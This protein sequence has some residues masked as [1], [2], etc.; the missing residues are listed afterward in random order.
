MFTLWERF[1]RPPQHR[2][3]CRS[4]LSIINMTENILKISFCIK[5]LNYFF[6][7]L[8]TSFFRLFGIG[9]MV[10]RTFLSKRNILSPYSLILLAVFSFKYTE[11]IHFFR[12]PFVSLWEIPS[13]YALSVILWRDFLVSPNLSFNR[14]SACFVIIAISSVL[15]CCSFNFLSL[16]ENSCQVQTIYY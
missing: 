15:S 13:V 2:H 5:F 11:S 8:F 7:S 12:F 6:I 4:F 9:R 10:M 3:L 14:F 16:S 1:Y